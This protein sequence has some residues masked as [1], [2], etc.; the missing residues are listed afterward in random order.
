[1]EKYSCIRDLLNTEYP[2]D[3]KIHQ[4][5]ETI[6]NIKA[7]L[8]SLMELLHFVK[9]LALA[10]DSTLEKEEIFYSRFEIYYEQ[11]QHLIPL[12]NKVRNFA[13]QKPYSIQKFKLNFENSTLLHGWDKNKEADNTC[14]LLRKEGKY[15]LGIMDKK[16]NKVF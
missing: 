9:P 3:K 5:K 15:Y 1:M 13:T 12:Y 11:L 7:F 6:E 2:K 16:H 4:D 14:V 8:D 10:K